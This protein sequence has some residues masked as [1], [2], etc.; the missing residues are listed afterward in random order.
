MSLLQ[1]RTINDVLPQRD[2]EVGSLTYVRRLND[3]GSMECRTSPANAWITEY[4][5]AGVFAQLYE[6]G[7]VEAVWRIMDYERSQSGEVKLYGED[8][9]YMLRDHVLR[10]PAGTDEA[11]F[12]DV[13]VY[14]AFYSLAERANTF[15]AVAQ[16]APAEQPVTN[17]PLP[18]VARPRASGV[19]VSFSYAW[20]SVLEA[21]QELVAA[22]RA[23]NFLLWFGVG[24]AS[25]YPMIRWSL[26]YG[27]PF[28]GQRRNIAF[29]ATEE[30]YTTSEEATVIVSLGRGVAEARKRAL[31][32]TWIAKSHRHRWRERRFDARN[33]QDVVST[34]LSAL[35]ESKRD[36]DLLSIVPALYPNRIDL[37]DVFYVQSST[38]G[39]REVSFVTGVK[40]DLGR[41]VHAEIETMEKNG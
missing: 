37:G 13:D 18:M 32:R 25:I 19:T 39:W 17:A 20:A 26:I 27:G 33:Y 15:P 41:A 40:V 35:Y 36:L 24:E 34:G 3:V 30:R 28:L 23:K 10:A 5:N 8:F 6:F 7:R 1:L 9:L 21:M 11:Q 12:S 16:N 4:I 2:L 14:A 29:Q 31:L 22:A 38:M